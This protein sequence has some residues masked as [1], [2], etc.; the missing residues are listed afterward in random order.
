MLDEIREAARAGSY[1]VTDH[2][3]RRLILRGIELGDVEWAIAQRS[4]V[5]EEYPE[6]H[7][8]PCCLILCQGRSGRW[9]HVVSSAAPAFAWITVYEPDPAQW[10][11]DFRRR[12]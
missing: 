3:L 9:Y 7:I 5:I 4:E 8:S 12:L 6:H 1:L 10:T 11:E 2:L